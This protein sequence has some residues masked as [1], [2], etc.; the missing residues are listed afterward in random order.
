MNRCWNSDGGHFPLVPKAGFAMQGEASHPLDKILNNA[1]SITVTGKGNPITVPMPSDT[2]INGVDTYRVDQDSGNTINA[3]YTM[4]GS[5]KTYTLKNF[6]MA[7]DIGTPYGLESWPSA[8]RFF[9]GF[10]PRALNGGTTGGVQSGGTTGGK[11]GGTSGGTE[12]L[13]GS[14]PTTTSTSP[15]TPGNPS[16]SVPIGSSTTPTSTAGGFA[17]LSEVNCDVQTPAQGS[18]TRFNDSKIQFKLAIGNGIQSLEVNYP[19]KWLPPVN[20]V[21]PM[22]NTHSPSAATAQPNG[23]TL[24]TTGAAYYI[25]AHMLTP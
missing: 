8:S 18:T 11:T 13:P 21:T 4:P 17:V 24:S 10:T 6:F 1:T 19:F 14:P 22:P 20:G 15:T 23:F 25:Y 12:P 9:P 2:V 3:T 7:P 16:V 5:S